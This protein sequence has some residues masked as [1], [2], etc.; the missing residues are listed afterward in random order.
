MHI[1]GKFVRGASSAGVALLLSWHAAQAQPVA[2]ERALRA[3]DVVRSVLQ[4]P[5]CQNC[6]IAG[7]SPFQDDRETP[8]EQFV[9]RGPTG[10]GA[11]GNECSSCHQKMNLPLSY[12]EH[13]PPG[14]PGWRLPPPETKMIF[15]GVSAGDLCRTLKNRRAT[16][17]R[18]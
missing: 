18:T 3:F 11:I 12:G 7:D 14:S 16:G 5:R 8:H 2:Q 13:A 15:N 6:H 17:G 4:H 1:M 9:V 10:R